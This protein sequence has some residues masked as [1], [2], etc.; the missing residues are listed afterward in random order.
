MA[1]PPAWHNAPESIILQHILAGAARVHFGTIRATCEAHSTDNPWAETEGLLGRQTEAIAR[2]WARCLDS[3]SA[4]SDQYAREEADVLQGYATRQGCPDLAPP[5]TQVA[6]LVAE[7]LP[8]DTLAS[9]EWR[10]KALRASPYIAIAPF[11]REFCAALAGQATVRSM[12]FLDANDAEALAQTPELVR[13]C[14]VIALGKLYLS[15]HVPQLPIAAPA[16]PQVV[17]TPRA[18]ALLLPGLSIGGVQ[19]LTARRGSVDSAGGSSV[20]TSF[21]GTGSSTISDGHDNSHRNHYD[22]ASMTSG[23]SGGARDFLPVAP[24]QS[25]N[26]SNSV[27]YGDMPPLIEPDYVPRELRTSASASNLFRTANPGGLSNEEVAG[28]G[29]DGGSSSTAS[30]DTWSDNTSVNTAINGLS[31]ASVLGPSV[32]AGDLEAM[33]DH[34]A[35][36][37]SR[38]DFA[39]DTD[40]DGHS[41]LELVARLPDPERAQQCLDVI[42]E[43]MTLVPQAD[44]TLPPEH[45]HA[46]ITAARLAGNGEVERALKGPPFW[47]VNEEDRKAIA[48][49]Q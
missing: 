31:L 5:I 13:Q 3:V 30:E 39:W 38:H 45:I 43:F 37:G 1:T 23:F 44:K 7:A 49:V 35:D 10:Q 29:A 25:P 19:D 28:T 2:M 20:G 24:P 17:V 41:V 4:W 34:L 11:W 47:A 21:T 42:M 22:T 48:T 18:P 15:T 26:T 27:L 12:R 6:K 40:G 8:H 36:V 16:P 9:A 14:I 46:A 32:S 33:R